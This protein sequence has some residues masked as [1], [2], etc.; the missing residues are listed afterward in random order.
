MIVD[1]EIQVNTAL[2]PKLLSESFAFSKLMGGPAN[3]L[4]FPNLES[5]NIAY[6]L[7]Q[8][9]AKFEVIGPVLNGLKEPVQVL[10]MGSSVS[11]IVNMITIAVLDAQSRKEDINKNR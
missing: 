10:Q 7:M 3:T 2:N 5:A 9:L 4:I 11:E 1:G 8:E 6:K